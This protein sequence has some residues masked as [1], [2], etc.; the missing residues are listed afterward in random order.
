MKQRVAD[1]VA[2]F[3]VNNGIDT[4]FSVVGGGSMFL[5]DAL[6]NKEGLSVTYTHHEQ[7][8]ALAAE[9]YARVKG[10]PAAVCVTTGPGG[11]N[12]LTGVLCAWQ[13]SM[14]MLVLSGQVRY[15]T[16]VESTGLPLRQFGEQEYTI[17]PSVEPMTKYCCMVKDP[18]D[19]RLCLERALWACN[20]GRRGPVWLDIPLNVQNATVETDTLRGFEPPAPVLK[21]E[22]IEALVT[23]LASAQRPV[24]LGGSGVR[25]A[26]VQEKFY[27]VVRR[28]NMP[29]CAATS[30]ADLY[31]VGDPL[32]CGNFGVSGGRAGNFLVQ[33]ADVLVSFGCSMAFKHVG[34]E[35]AAFAPDAK[36]AVVSVD[37]AELRKPTITID[38][39]LHCDMEA[40]FDALLERELPCFANENGWLDYAEWLPKSL[41]VYQE[42]FDHSDSVNQYYLIKQLNQLLPAD[43]IEVVGNSVAC[44][45]VLQMGVSHRGQRLFGNANCGTMG[46]DLP[47]AIGATTAAK[48]EVYLLTGDGSI[49]MNIQELA[50]VAFRNLP[51][52]IIVFNNEGYQAVVTSQTNNFKRLS[53]CTADSGL[54]MPS[55]KGLAA[56]YGISYLKIKNHAE[57][58]DKL[59]ELVSAN[60]PV[61]CEVMQDQTQGI[62]PKQQSKKLPDGTMKSLPLFDMYP[63]LSDEDVAAM[64]FS[65]KQKAWEV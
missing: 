65:S 59:R 42:K 30:V 33:N 18:E 4:T 1:Y 37:E 6:G 63:Y 62:E 51:V 46:Y 45:S 23:L 7:A 58:P 20:E 57:T 27:E 55:F 19:I 39:P 32:Y 48:H 49:Q 29:V 50:T 12:A 38:L 15:E 35:F 60:G 34:F 47:A 21:H 11:T 28:L 8:A 53:G 40:L 9:G 2:D 64:Q 31:A 56:A 54:G 61:I 44:V 14:P 3:L 25:S 41:P 13:D 52:K 16:T 43:S 10:A 5:N 17:I 36:K 26:G 22:D 24:L